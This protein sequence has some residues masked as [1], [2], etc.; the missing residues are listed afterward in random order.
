MLFY[1]KIKK[2]KMKIVLPS[3]LFNEQGVP[4]ACDG[5]AMS[6]EVEDIMSSHLFKVMPDLL[7]IAKKTP[8]K[9]DSEASISADH[10]L[11]YVQNN[12][13]YVANLDMSAVRKFIP[14]N[15]YQTVH[16]DNKL[17]L[18]EK[19]VFSDAFF[20][21]TAELLSITNEGLNMFGDNWFEKYLNVFIVL[22]KVLFDFL[23][24]SNHLQH[25][26]KLMNQYM[27]CISNSPSCLEY[28]VNNR[29]Y[30][31]E[32]LLAKNEKNFFETV[33]THASQESRAMAAKL[34]QHILAEVQKNQLVEVEQRIVQSMLGQMD[35]ECQK[36]WMRVEEYFDALYKVMKSSPTAMRTMISSGI[37]SRGIDLL[38]KYKP[39]QLYEGVSAP[40]GNLVK[41]I[42]TPPLLV[43]AIRDPT[44]APKFDLGSSGMNLEPQAFFGCEDQLDVFMLPDPCLNI[45]FQK[46]KAQKEMFQLIAKN[47]FAIAE[48]K[49]FLAHLCFENREFSIRVAKFILKGTIKQYY[50]DNNAYLELLK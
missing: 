20:N 38:M 25:I 4:L 1:E 37:V 10:E 40:L 11:V 39:N 18:D 6:R 35:S 5:A 8:V 44:E 31:N 49:V 43:P 28:A 33:A 46:T 50:D 7:P 27:E 36:H 9:V 23:V 13:E 42:V 12:K 19:L 26:E 22:D 30:M 48:F 34:I 3:E 41:L 29:L 45:L 2:K 21:T 24:N 32:E 47:N 16:V 15:I 17:H 14:K